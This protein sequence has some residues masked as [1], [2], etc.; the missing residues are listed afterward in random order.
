MGQIFLNN[1]GNGHTYCVP[2]FGSTM[3][4]GE[5]FTVYFNPDSGATLNDVRAYDSYDYPITLP[6][7]VNNEMTMNFRTAWRNMYLS[8]Y[9]SGS[10]PPPTH[11]SFMTLICLLASKKKR[12]RYVR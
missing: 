11:I 1:H 5:Q 7:I 4:D 6:S 9:Y 10:E 12:R 2:P 8:V 3:I